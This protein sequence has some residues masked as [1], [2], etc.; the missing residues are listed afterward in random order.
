LFDPR[1][2]SGSADVVTHDSAQYKAISWLM[3]DMHN[4]KLLEEWSVYIL[5]GQTELQQQCC[6]GKILFGR[7]LKIS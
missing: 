7:M 4:K 5:Q 1:V 6:S 3:K 2:D